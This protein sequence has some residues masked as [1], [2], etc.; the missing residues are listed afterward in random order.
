MEHIVR[1]D[2][3][4]LPTITFSPAA[5]MYVPWTWFSVYH[6]KMASLPSRRA[7]VYLVGAHEAGSSR[8]ILI[9]ISKSDSAV[10]RREVPRVWTQVCSIRSAIHEVRA[11]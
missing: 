9:S 2:N 8:E 4:I 6:P 10:A 7:L 11:E 1:V 3:E 5:Y